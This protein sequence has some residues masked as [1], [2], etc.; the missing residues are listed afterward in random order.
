MYAELWIWISGIEIINVNPENPGPEIFGNYIYKL[1]SRNPNPQLWIQLPI[2]PSTRCPPD[3][4]T[5]KRNQ[6]EGRKKIK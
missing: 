2:F 3:H 6:E 1:N 4:N 5:Y